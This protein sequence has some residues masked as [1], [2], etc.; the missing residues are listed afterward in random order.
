[1]Y[2]LHDSI[3][4]G[5]SYKVRLILSNLKIPYERRDIDIFRGETRTDEFR[6]INPLQKVPV[7]ETDDRRS[8]AESQRILWFLGQ[9]TELMP[10][11]DVIHEVIYWF[12]VVQAY[13]EPGIARIRF[14]RKF[15]KKNPSKF[16]E[17]YEERKQIATSG[18]LVLE[19]HLQT[20][21]FLV[22]QRYSIAD[23]AVY[24]Y[25]QLA[26]EA[27]FDLCN[28]P[29]VMAWIDRV[30]SIAGHIPMYEIPHS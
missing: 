9:D 20:V 30:S 4:S 5:N 21:Q 27:G 12:S 13:I 7:L 10:D 11:S 8:F 17:N 3:P 14:W 2:V 26:G 1:M 23:I 6:A 16:G 25:T 18:L 22:G 15:S 19:Q 24:G 29:A 28:Y